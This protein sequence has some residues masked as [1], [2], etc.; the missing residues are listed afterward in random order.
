MS[1]N[2]AYD[3]DEGVFVGMKEDGKKYNPLQ[4]SGDSNWLPPVD[5]QD[6]LNDKIISS[7][8]KNREIVI[9]RPSIKKMKV[10]FPLLDSNGDI[11]VDKDGLPVISKIRK[12]EVYIGVEKRS[13]FFPIKDWFNDSVTS[14]VLEKTEAQFIRETDD[15]A[16]SLW[17]EQMFNPK[18][19]HSEFINKLYWLKA[20]IADVSKGV[21]GVA[22][23]HAKTT[24]SKGENLVND[25]R[26]DPILEHDKKMKKSG[27]LGMG[28]LGGLI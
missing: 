16:F 13:F 6:K 22:V 17:I 9:T 14:S 23:V 27:I 26:R 19:D 2:R 4:S 21:G 18:I 20:S 12:M 25:Y 28:W 10:A 15:L 5:S 1:E 24:I 11:T 7:H 8:N 3:L